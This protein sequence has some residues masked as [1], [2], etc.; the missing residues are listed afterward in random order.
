VAVRPTDL[1][2]AVDDVPPLPRL[3]ALG[4]QYAILLSVYLIIVVIVAKAAEATPEETAD[5]VSLGLIA[6]ALATTVQ[7]WNGR[8]FGSGYLA[9]PV[10]SAIY[11]GP[12]ILAAKAGGLPAVAG[13]TIFAGV[14]EIGLSRLLD[15]LRIVFQP[16]I[17]GFTVLVVG[18]QLGL[19]GIANTLDV[20]DENTPDFAWHVAT[21]FLTL[22]ACVGF[23]IW[24]RGVV[25]LISTLLG[26]VIGVGVGLGTGLIGPPLFSAVA[27]AEW[28]DLPDPGFLSYGF[29]PALIPAFLAAAIAATLRTIGV[30]TTC[31]RLND[32]AWKRPDMANIRRGVTADG[33]GCLA[34]GLFGAPG[35]SSAPSLVGVSSAT[36]AT[37]R[38]IAYATAAILV[39][40]AFIPK[41]GAA[42]IALPLEIAGA[43]LVFT[44]TFMVVGGIQI[45]AVRGL[46]LR[47]G[48]AVSVALFVGILTK[49]HPGYFAKL[50]E[51]LQTITSD[52]LTVSLA[53]AI[54]MTLIFRIGIRR[55]D[56]IHWDAADASRDELAAF[57]AREAKAW[58][59]DGD[60][61]E[62]VADAVG[63][64]VEHLKEGGFLAEPVAIKASFDSLE[65]TIALVYRGRPL[66]LPTH[67][68]G[69]EQQHEEASATVGLASFFQS[70]FADRLSLTRSGDEVTIRLWFGV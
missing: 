12:A 62:R 58:K 19:V 66:P 36:G 16:T 33:L 55:R 56:A 38:V 4:L 43:I 23:S 9:P 22:A 8:F 25:K 6:A 50:P 14:L 10:Y 20:P 65:L 41:I 59:L 29:E 39:V 37:S 42:I 47:S 35:Q 13:M 21:A 67:H 15:R 52:M 40:F 45:M 17:A 64:L 28:L 53:V 69:A 27:E 46:D 7:A 1:V 44:A 5:L 26:L 31:Q 54:G 61:V 18:L 57:L 48:F 63:Q 30:V 49:V 32:A 51:A 60:V 11:F 34:A 70:A 24:G 2:Y 3:A 68:R